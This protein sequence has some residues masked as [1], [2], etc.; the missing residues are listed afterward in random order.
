LLSQA[1]AKS[2]RPENLFSP[3]S[4]PIIG[5]GRLGELFVKATPEGL[6]HLVE[7]IERNKSDQ[8]TK[9][10]SCIESIEPIT[11]T[12][13]RRGLEAKDVLHRSPRGKHGFITR[14]RLFNLGA[15]VDQPKLVED[16]T[17]VC[18]QR[19]IPISQ[20]GYSPSSFTY[21]I[22]CRDVDDVEALSRVIGVRSITHMPVIRTI[23]PRMFN[24]KPLPA[25]PNRG[26]AAGDFP[27][28]V[29]VD[30]GVSPSIPALESWVVGRDSQVAPQYQNSDHG[31]FV[32]G[33]ICWG[34]GAKP[35]DLRFGEQPVRCIWSAGDPERGPGQ[36]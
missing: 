30:S 8:M 2:H 27:V 11:P 25:L 13:R 10:L 35:D 20:D 3:L 34:S 9:E 5:S 22:E 24:A 15:D 36:R 7:T 31:T 18:R 14:V 26:D 29:V 17:S 33:L 23:R 4:C 19:N 21:G 32:A 12:F 16:F 1:A 6:Q 28:V